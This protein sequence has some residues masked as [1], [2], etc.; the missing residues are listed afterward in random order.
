VNS[1]QTTVTLTANSRKKPGSGTTGTNPELFDPTLKD[2]HYMSKTRVLIVDD[3]KLVQ[4]VLTAVLKSDSDLD[5]VGLA[6]NGQQA[7]ERVETLKP[8][9]VTMD[10]SMP[11][12]DGLK[13]I[14]NI[15]AT[16]PVPILVISDIQDSHVAFIALKRGALEVISKSDL[17]PEKSGELIRKIKLLAKVKVIRHIRGNLLDEAKQLDT[18]KETDHGLERV[19]AIASST[20]GPRALATILAALPADFPYPILI[21]QHIDQGFIEGL[22]DF[23]NSVCSL[24]VKQGEIEKLKKV[25][26]TVS[27][28]GKGKTDKPE[29]ERARQRIQRAVKDAINN[30]KDKNPALGKYLSEHIKTGEYC[31]YIS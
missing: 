1:R 22:V 12:L 25:L 6:D 18:S 9:L 26:N 16:N 5:V 23:I 21:A 17:Q 14:S 11:V 19:V 10:I 7:I 31:S 15:M 27:F 28:K 8:D 4:E 20:G 2:N 13:A 3:S 29:I 30:I 24:K